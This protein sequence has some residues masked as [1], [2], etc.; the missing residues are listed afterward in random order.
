MALLF[1]LYWARL[2]H[3][4]CALLKSGWGGVVWCQETMDFPSKSRFLLLRNQMW[5]NNRPCYTPSIRK[6]L[7]GLTHDIRHQTEI[8][9]LHISLR[10]LWLVFEFTKDFSHSFSIITHTWIY[11]AILWL[12][13]DDIL[14]C[15]DC[16]CFSF[17][18]K[19]FLKKEQSSF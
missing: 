9:K 19:T 5:V 14:L 7:C 16:H 4:A 1:S 15:T 3:L 11:G 18:S 17:N 2:Y 13:E 10:M 12:L 8:D 6:R